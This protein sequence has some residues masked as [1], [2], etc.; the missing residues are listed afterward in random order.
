MKSA[1]SN[2][3]PVDTVSARTLELFKEHHQNIIQHT[4]QLFSRLMIWQWLFG[5]VLAIWISPR[6]WAGTSSQVHFHVWAAVLLGAIVT[7]APVLLACLQ[8]GKPLTRHVIAIG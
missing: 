8:P 3:P 2:T 6:T 4:D 7:S 5:V 1:P